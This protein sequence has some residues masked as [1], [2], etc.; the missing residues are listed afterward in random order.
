MK[1]KLFLG[2]NVTL[3]ATAVFAV[4]LLVSGSIE[5]YSSPGSQPLADL[6]AESLDGEAVSLLDSA[7]PT[8][9]LVMSPSCAVAADIV[10]DWANVLEGSLP[11][12]VRTAIVA[13]D[14][15]GAHAVTRYLDQRGLDMETLLVP[16]DLFTASTG[17]RIV[18]SVLLI[19]TGGEVLF[20]NEGKTEASSLRDEILDE[21]E[22]AMSET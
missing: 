21:L 16:H 20:V 17:T 15:D 12:Y 13:F 18:P 2:V 5:G 1:G 3:L 4:G 14:T 22:I 9:L 6:P 11:P 8:V 10:P 19:D 7:R